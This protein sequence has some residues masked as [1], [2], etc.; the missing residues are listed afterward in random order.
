[1]IVF[2]QCQIACTCLCR[3]FTADRLKA[4]RHRP[5]CP[6]RALELPL[7]DLSFDD[8]DISLSQ[9]PLRIH[10]CSSLLEFNLLVSRLG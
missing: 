2:D 7:I 3:M 4:L 6:D 8:R 10:D 5:L 1:M 9:G